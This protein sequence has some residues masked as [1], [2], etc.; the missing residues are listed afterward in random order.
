[1]VL[2]QSLTVSGILPG[3]DQRTK[4]LC[5]NTML[6]FGVT[7]SDSGMTATTQGNWYEY[8]ELDGGASFGSTPSPTV[9]EARGNHLGN[10][11]ASYDRIEDHRYN[12]LGRLISQIRAYAGELAVL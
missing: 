10:F 7:F 8:S 11:F 6:H 12:K 4:P 3:K 9:T 1:M 2:S 5:P